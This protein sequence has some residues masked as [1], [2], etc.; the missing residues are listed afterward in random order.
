MWQKTEFIPLDTSSNLVLALFQMRRTRR[1]Q[2]MNQ[3]MTNASRALKNL[4]IPP[5]TMGVIMPKR[6]IEPKH[7]DITWSDIGP[8]FIA[9]TLVET[10]HTKKY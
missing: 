3:L 2:G 8:N 7:F 5:G 1:T 10:S 6:R 9:P 4:E